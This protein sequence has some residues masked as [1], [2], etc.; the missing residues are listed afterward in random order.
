MTLENDNSTHIAVDN[1]NNNKDVKLNNAATAESKQA[2]SI[3]TISILT[4]LP[5]TTLIR[6]KSYFADVDEVAD[7][8]LLGVEIDVQIGQM[9]LRSKHLE[10][11]DKNISNHPDVAM[12]FGDATIQASMVEKA[13]HRIIYRL[14]GLNHEIEHWKTPH[15]DCPP[16]GDEW[17]REYDPAD[18]SESEKWIPGV[19]N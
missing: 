17:E 5:T 19:F 6:R 11:L 3:N 15:K 13:E 12:I 8:G 4:P 2:L 7:N 16:A 1:S 14:V 9:T 10:A 18:L